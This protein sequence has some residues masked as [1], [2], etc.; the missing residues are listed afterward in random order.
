MNIDKNKLI[1]K[2][3]NNDQQATKIRPLIISIIGA[4]GKTQLSFWLANFFKQHGHSV[5]VTTTTK[6]YLPDPAR[7][8]NILTLHHAQA[9]NEIQTPSST[10]VY[11]EKLAKTNANEPIKVQGLQ[12]QDVTH[13]IESSLF[14]VLIIEADGAK[15]LPIKAPAAHE[16][17]IEQASSIVIAVTGAEAI[18]AKATSN[19]VHRWA[20]FSALT[21]CLVNTEINYSVLK[22]LLDNPQG[23]FKGAP[24]HAVKI[25]A[26]N[27][28]DLC[29]DPSALQVLSNR[30]LDESPI[31]TSIWLTQ[32][33]APTAIKNVLIR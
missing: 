15:H 14:S 7:V 1:E 11:R 8:D 13:I 33:N 32:L 26:I 21:H 3:L 19:N 27:K 16:P 6:M 25:W 28:Y 22:R 9:S 24:E 4:G 2:L 23:M 12:Q 5:C 17:C 31:L 18:F 10:F 30:L 20:E 29:A